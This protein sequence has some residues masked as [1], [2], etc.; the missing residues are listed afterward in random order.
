ME[1]RI[2]KFGSPDEFINFNKDFLSVNEAENNI[3]IGLAKQLSNKTIISKSFILLSI[4][5]GEE[6]IG[7][8]FR[9]SSDKPLSI[10]K[11]DIDSIDLIINYLHTNKYVLQGCLADK[12]TSKYFVSKWANINGVNYKLRKSQGIY[13]ITHVNN[14]DYNDGMLVP[15]T[16]AINNT[17]MRFLRLF[18]DEYYNDYELKHNTASNILKNL[19]Q[20]NGL[21]FLKNSHLNY[22][23]MGS[24]IRIGFTSLTLGYIFTLKESR[25]KGY[26]EILLYHLVKH[27][28]TRDNIQSCNLF[29]NMDNIASIT[30]YEK[31]GFK[32]L[33]IYNH[34]E[35][36]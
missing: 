1:K 19:K 13:E 9:T 25:R 26:G 28:L 27:A 8:A 10:S 22:V 24:I 21:Y 35:L 14:Q 36:Q 6:I 32:F 11:M 31:L 4:V 30:L 17:S 5:C 33:T 20:I 29:T 16:E 15:Y 12:N 2:I 3:V 7:Y 34:Y 23:S 18:C